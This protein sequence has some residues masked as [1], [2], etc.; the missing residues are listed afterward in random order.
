LDGSNIKEESRLLKEIKD[1]IDELT[2]MEMIFSIQMETMVDH[3]QPQECMFKIKAMKARA[4]ATNES[5]GIASKF[6]GRRD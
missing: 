4:K 5:V 1:I 3:A 2:M 6:S